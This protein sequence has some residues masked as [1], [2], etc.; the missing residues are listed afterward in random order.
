[1]GERTSQVYVIEVDGRAVAAFE[2]ISG[3]EARELT[4][5]DW[6][7]DD[8]AELTS[9]GSPIWRPDSS[10]LIRAATANE[11]SLFWQAPKKEVP[12]ELTLA[13]LVALNQ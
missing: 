1:M 7:K 11:M 6:L 3:K 2:A 8:L 12:G 5:E 9:D 10:M 4:K 13:Y